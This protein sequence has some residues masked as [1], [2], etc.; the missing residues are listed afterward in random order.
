MMG[1][2]P[3]ILGNNWLLKLWK[4]GALGLQFGIAINA[5]LNFLCRL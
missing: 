2:R 4:E 1:L 5:V 3:I